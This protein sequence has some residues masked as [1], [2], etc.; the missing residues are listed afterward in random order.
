MISKNVEKL[1]QTLCVE[2]HLLVDHL[3]DKA[4]D[5]VHVLD[6]PCSF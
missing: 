5:G 1:I 4:D 2:L 6:D 3:Q